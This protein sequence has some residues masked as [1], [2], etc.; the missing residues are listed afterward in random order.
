MKQPI[1]FLAVFTAVLGVL[2]ALGSAAPAQR[3]EPITVAATTG[4]VADL[5]RNTGGDHV[6]VKTII[7]TGADPH[8]YKPTRGDVM[9]F[10]RADMI[11]YNGQH[12]EGQMGDMLSKMAARKPVVAVAEAIDPER[13]LEADGAVDPH[14]WMHVD[15]WMETLEPVEKALSEFAPAHREDFAA[16][17]AA[18]REELK[19]LA[20]YVRRVTATIPEGKRYLV[21]AHDAFGYFGAAYDMDVRGI[22]GLS[23]ESEAGLQDI[24]RLVDLI[25]ERGIPAVFVET[26]VSDKN[27]RALLE[28]ARSRGQEVRIGGSLFS[29]AMGPEGTYE[30]TYIGMLDHNATVITRA[31]GGEAP[32]DGLNGKL[33]TSGEAAR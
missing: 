9:A 26:S 22:Q 3:S 11:F 18:Y 10:S 24:N 29:D 30:G 16:N 8:I 4:M 33:N 21:T 5:V 15:L 6:D 31:L 32:R 28:G 17:A 7:G 1:R 23:T 25:V 13:L 19:H 14:V 27:V 12:L 20:D 2:A